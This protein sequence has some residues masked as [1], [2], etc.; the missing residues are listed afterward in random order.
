MSYRQTG[1]SDEAKSGAAA[2][3]FVLAR[4]HGHGSTWR[5]TEHKE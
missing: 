1:A 5:P 2:A 3:G 4:S